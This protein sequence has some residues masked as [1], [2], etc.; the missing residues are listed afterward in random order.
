MRLS[1]Q[2][3]NRDIRRFNLAQRLMRLEA[4]TRTICEW[5][6]LSMARVR[7]LSRSC[8]IGGRHRGPPP[9]K[10]TGFLQ[11]RSLCSEAS[12]MA[13]LA[14]VL[15]AVPPRPVPHA[16]KV[17][18]SV[19]LGEKLCQAFEIFR[20]VVPESRFSIDHFILLALSLAEGEE[21]E[22]GHCNHCQAVLL[23]DRLSTRPRQCQSCKSG[24]GQKSREEFLT[25]SSTIAPR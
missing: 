2:R 14:C 8:G 19:E 22:V 6:G 21:L 25:G 5:T 7:N 1:E 20:R 17:L 12:A 18:P 10:L 15:G 3:Y 13:G 16:R 11:S 23:L 24:D 4:R 9:T